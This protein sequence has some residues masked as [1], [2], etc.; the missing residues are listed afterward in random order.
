MPAR[1]A[2]EPACRTGLCQL[3]RQVNLLAELVYNSTRSRASPLRDVA[4]AA[5]KF[6]AKLMGIDTSW[7]ATATVKPLRCNVA[8]SVWIA[9]ICIGDTVHRYRSVRP[10]RCT[11]FKNNA[12]VPPIRC[13]NQIL[14]MWLIFSSLPWNRISDRLLGIAF[15]YSR[16]GVGIYSRTWA[17]SEAQRL[18]LNLKE[19]VMKKLKSVQSKIS[20]IHNVWTTKGNRQAFMGIAAAYTL[21]ENLARMAASEFILDPAIRF[22]LGC[23]PPSESLTDSNSVAKRPGR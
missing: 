14:V 17:A 3:G 23:A 7:H 4:V 16:K 13:M 21:P 2:G 9:A 22:K 1:Q 10:M 20:L 12:S 5:L 15:G 6:R 8:V 11:F 18:Y 19:K